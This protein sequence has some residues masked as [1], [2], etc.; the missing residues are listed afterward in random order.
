MKDGI[1]SYIDHVL[2]TESY[3]E[4]ILNCI[5]CSDYND[6]TSDHFPIQTKISINLNI[7]SDTCEKNCFTNIKTVPQRFWNNPTFI[8][9]YKNKLSRSLNCPVYA[10]NQDTAQSFVDSYCE[11]LTLVL[12]NAAWKTKESIQSDYTLRSK[13]KRNFW[14]DN[15][16]KTANCRLKFWFQLWKSCERPRQGCIYDCYK[17]V[18][19]AY[20]K[21]CRKA[22]NCASRKKFELCNNLFKEKRMNKFWNQV[23]QSRRTSQ[24]DDKSCISNETFES[25]FREKFSYDKEKENE[26]VKTS[27][28]TVNNKLSNCVSPFNKFVFSEHILIKYIKALK[29]NCSPGVDRISPEHLKYAVQPNIIKHLCRM[30]TVCLQFSVV[31]NSFTKGLLVPLLKKPTSDAG[32]AKNYRPVVL[33]TIYSKILEMYILDEVSDFTFNDFQ[34]GFVKGR[35]TSTATALAHDVASYC[36][37]NGSQVYM[38]SLTSLTVSG[39]QKLIDTANKYVKNHGL[40]FNPTKTSCTIQGKLLFTVQP[41]WYIDECLLTTK[42]NLNYLGSIVGNNCG[43]DHILSRLS[44]CRKSFYALQG[45]GL[46]QEGLNIKTAMYV[47]SVTSMKSLLYGCETLFI[48]ETKR[49]ELDVLQ[50]KLLKCIVGIGPQ[51]RT[52]P[53]LKALKICKSSVHID[54]NS[55]I[56]LKNIFNNDSAARKIYIDML[57][58]NNKCKNILSTRVSN[59]CHK[60]DVDMMK[61][62]LDTSYMTSVKNKF[63]VIQNMA[64]MVLQTQ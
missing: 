12:H 8:S 31:P 26:F 18:K 46:C 64:K 5:I 43:A 51:Y 52:S 41:Q 47:W 6:C 60:Y 37:Q 13:R 30:F 25:F 29:S 58:H 7:T 49:H 10:I 54:F 17:S 39:L 42:T 24:N 21:V 33:S 28:E 22:F 1:R 36:T 15:D 55:L 59:I 16:C 23:K 11:Q 2:I 50:G 38:C 63:S 20:R 57:H 32:V 4:N 14:W 34:F 62:L 45:A 35:G 9:T 48:T 44:A 53:L 40:R 27:R 19:S 3:R 61:L 56:L